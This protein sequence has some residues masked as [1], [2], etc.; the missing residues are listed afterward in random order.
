MVS[1]VLDFHL[2]F[3]DDASYPCYLS[4]SWLSLELKNLATSLYPH[5]SG[6]HSVQTGL[7]AIAKCLN[8]AGT[9]SPNKTDI[10]YKG[11]GTGT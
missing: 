10:Y 1:E 6:T 7:I 2:F 11:E 8:F 3:S 5:Y 9:F 4:Q